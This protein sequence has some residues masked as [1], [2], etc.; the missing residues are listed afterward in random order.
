MHTSGSDSDGFFI[1]ENAGIAMTS[2]IDR[3][4]HR[5]LAAEQRFRQVEQGTPLGESP[6]GLRMAAH[7]LSVA[8][9]EAG[10][11]RALVDLRET[12]IRH[13]TAIEQAVATYRDRDGLNADRFR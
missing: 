9:D 5:L 12:L 10:G 8:F 2:A 3:A 6:A 13:R 7:N 11:L 4:L 1:S